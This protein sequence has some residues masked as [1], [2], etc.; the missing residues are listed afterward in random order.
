MRRRHLRPR[1]PYHRDHAILELRLRLIHGR[2]PGDHPELKIGAAPEHPR[3]QRGGGGGQRGVCD[4]TVSP[5][6]WVAPMD[7]MGLE[8]RHNTTVVAGPW[9][10]PR[11][12]STPLD[13]HHHRGWSGR[14]WRRA[15]R[16][17]LHTHAWWASR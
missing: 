16:G 1:A 7:Q 6:A 10:L 14:P 3:W 8:E 2:R 5:P 9:A 15:Y 17:R 12:C 13:D 11:K 4:A